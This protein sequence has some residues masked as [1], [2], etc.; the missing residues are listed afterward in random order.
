MKYFGWIVAMVLWLE[1]AWLL[2]TMF[3]GEFLR[4]LMWPLIPVLVTLMGP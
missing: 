1:G 4:A 3:G 2:S